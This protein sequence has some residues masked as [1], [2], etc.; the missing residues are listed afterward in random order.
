MQTT[1]CIVPS[2]FVSNEMTIENQ[3]N[4]KIDSEEWR[5]ENDKNHQSEPGKESKISSVEPCC[6]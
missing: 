4:Q 1:Q 5:I 6:F 2:K 3:E